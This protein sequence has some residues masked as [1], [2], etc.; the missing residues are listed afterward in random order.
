MRVLVVIL[1]S[2]ALSLPYLTFEVASAARF[3]TVS[4]ATFNISDLG[5]EAIMSGTDFQAK[6]VAEIIQRVN[7]DVLSMNEIAYDVS[8]VRGAQTRGENARKFVENYLMIPQ[9]PGL[10]SLDYPYVFFEQGNTGVPTGKDLNNDGRSDGPD[11]GYGFGNYEGQFSM[12]LLSRYPIVTAQVRT[13]RNFLWKDMPNNIIPPNYYTGDE[14]A[15]FRLSS[16]SHWDI[17]ISIGGMIIHVIMAHPTPPVFDGPEDRNGRRNHDEIRLI[18]DYVSRAEYVYDDKGQRRGLSQGAK[19]VLM[20]DMNADPL[21]G[22]STANAIDQLLK[23]PLISTATLPTGEGGIEVANPGHKNLPQYDTADFSDPN[24]GN[25]QADYVLPSRDLK[26]KEAKVFWPKKNDPLYPIVDAA[27][28]HR[29]VWLAVDVEVVSN[30]PPISSISYS[31]TSPKISDEINFMDKSLDRD[32]EIVS[33]RWDFGDGTSSNERNPTHKYASRGT[34]RV[35]L[36]VRDNDGAVGTTETRIKLVSLPPTANF[37]YSPTSPLEGEEVGFTD[38]STDPD[39]VIKSRHWD[40]GDGTTSTENSPRH[41][42]AKPGAF[43]VTLTVND[44]DDLSGKK[45]QVIDVS[46]LP[47]RPI[48]TEPLFQVLIVAVLSI[49]AIVA[50]RIVRKK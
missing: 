6:M 29:L 33:Y 25:L 8:G 43:K 4:F 28:D 40:F 41:K 50:F 32:G 45:E 21:D 3:I 49:A 37:A 42:F 19:F 12:A 47:L 16:K 15:I 20:G 48:W 38:L 46:P 27:S 35:K 22:D 44:D 14:L 9:K 2:Y 5:T 36:T 13:F 39:G 23:H 31:P 18:A 10:P 24:P 26:A 7:P 34:F 1:L 17:P 30:I 11:D